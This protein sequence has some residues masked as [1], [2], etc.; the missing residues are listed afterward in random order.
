[1][2]DREEINVWHRERR[3]KLKEAGLCGGCGIK[4]LINEN[5][6]CKSCKEK[7]NA[8]QKIWKNKTIASRIAKGLCACGKKSRDGKKTCAECA[9]KYRIR[10]KNRK[11]KGLCSDCANKAISGKVRCI[12]CSEKH[13]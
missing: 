10:A 4:L 5:N 11:L 3:K 1:M 12:E 13:R 2:K 9:N 6:K 7:L 8:Y